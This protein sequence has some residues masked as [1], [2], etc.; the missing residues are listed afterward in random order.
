MFAIRDFLLSLQ[1]RNCAVLENEYSEQSGLAQ[2][3]LLF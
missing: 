2:I 3:V 1:P